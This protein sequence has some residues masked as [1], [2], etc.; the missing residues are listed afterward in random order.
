MANK[1]RLKCPNNHL[2]EIESKFAGMQV[3]CPACQVIMLVPKVASPQSPTAPAVKQATASAQASPTPLH[4]ELVEDEDDE[5]EEEQ[6]EK[7]EPRRPKFK[8]GTKAGLRKVRTGLNYNIAQLYVIV[9]G[10]LVIFALGI[11]V[12]ANRANVPQ[13]FPANARFGQQAQQGFGLILIAALVV[14]LTYVVLGILSAIYVAAVPEQ[15]HAKGLAI[16]YAILGTAGGLLKLLQL[17]VG[18][19]N[20]ASEFLGLLQ[21]CFMVSGLICFTIV[22]KRL[23]VFLKKPK[24]V[25]KAQG[26]LTLVGVTAGGYFMIF[27]GAIG[28][29]ERAP[30]DPPGAFHDIALASMMIGFLVFIIFAIWSFFRYIRLIHNVRDAL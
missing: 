27:L 23:C 12:A 1:L 30:G 25:K 16:T 15:T 26:L 5:L 17:F 4:H 9:I 28:T 24:L 21:M 6:E 13:G 20:A 8:S 3:Q 22:L 2:L 7:W 10:V 14:N 11:A 29:L 18:K 19:G